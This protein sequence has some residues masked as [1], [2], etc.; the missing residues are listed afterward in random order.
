[1]RRAE[2][3][4]ILKSA[5]ALDHFMHLQEELA[6]TESQV[7]V[8]RQKHETAEAL[9]SGSLKLVVERANLLDRLRREYAEQ[10][11]VI[12]DAVL[13]F[14]R[15]SSQMYEEGKEGKLRIEPTDNGP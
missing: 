13:T 8:L 14:R 6:R 2:I 7:E 10:A 12:E 9:E 15:I 4:S 11:T 3:M 5:G 1:G